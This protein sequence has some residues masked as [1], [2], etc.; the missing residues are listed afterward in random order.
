MVKLSDLNLFIFKLALDLTKLMESYHQHQVIGIEKI[1][2]EGPVLVVTNHSLASYDGYLLAH[3][4]IELRNRIP[5]WLGDRLLFKTPIIKNLA[6]ICHVIEASPQNAKSKLES[7][8]IIILAPGGTKE[9]LRNSSEKYQIKWEG[10]LGF[11]KVAI[12]AQCPIILAPC[13]GGDDVYHVYK[14]KIS[15]FVYNKFKIPFPLF[16]GIG[17]TLLPKPVK[18]THFLSDPIYPPSI[19]DLNHTNRDRVVKEFHHKVTRQ[20]QE[21]L[22]KG[23][24]NG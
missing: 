15:P 9:A 2:A 13:F 21:M 16:R 14:N 6:E 10:R 12:E 19:Q 11:I 8:E 24:S 18:I 5:I 20:M 4:I 23:I 22:N 7:G 17:P 3:D 1:P